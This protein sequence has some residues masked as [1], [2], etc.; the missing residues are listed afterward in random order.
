MRSTCCSRRLMM[1]SEAQVERAIALIQKGGGNYEYFFQQLSNPSWIAPLERV[2][3]TAYRIPAWP[4][5]Q[6][7]LRMAAV[8]PEEVTAAIGAA[9]FES[10]NPAVHMLLVEIAGIVPISG[11]REIA[12]RELAWLEKQ[13]SLFTL[14]PQKAAS[15]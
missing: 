4:E 8:A 9:C 13:R 15:L 3:K 1:P 2:S 11:A 14:Y 5:G 6:Y 12:T 10:D 7:L